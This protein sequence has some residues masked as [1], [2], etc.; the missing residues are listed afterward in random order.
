MN[1]II[2]VKLA[3]DFDW[4]PIETSSRDVD[5]KTYTSIRR[6]WSTAAIDEY[7]AI[8]VST[9]KLHVILRTNESV[10]RY[11]LDNIN[12]KYKI[13][14]NGETYVKGTE[15]AHIIDSRLHS[16]G[17]LTQEKYLRESDSMYQGMKNSDKP[18]L[19]RAEWYEKLAFL[20]RE[21]RKIRISHLS[22][23]TDE[24]SGERLLPRK[25]QFSHIRSVATHPQL[26][27]KI[28]NGLIV[29]TD[30]HKIITTREVNDEEQLYDLCLEYEWQTN[31]YSTYKENID[32]L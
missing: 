21:L 8:W 26:A 5:K 11:Y 30:L 16:A 27:D 18:R 12:D 20:K 10:A 13:T 14:V 15:V 22:I 9:L 25:S 24:L 1:E 2:I 7:G 28:W 29:H 3:S 31:W 17:S 23:T 6:A 4:R 32:N 19:V